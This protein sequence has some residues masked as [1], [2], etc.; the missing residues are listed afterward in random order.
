M[1]DDFI[2]YVTTDRHGQ[3]WLA[4]RADAGC[5]TENGYTPVNS[6]LADGQ[7]PM[8]QSNIS[9]IACDRQGNIY[10]T[11]RTDGVYFA[12][13]TPNGRFSLPATTHCQL[14]A[15]NVYLLTL[16]TAYG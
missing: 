10:I 1:V 13:S 7:T 11:S 15:A 16:K 3:L 6:M 8:P 12:T 2:N 5:L 9:A 4:T 14:R